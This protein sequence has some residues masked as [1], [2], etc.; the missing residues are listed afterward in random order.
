MGLH[1]FLG[2]VRQ[3]A[4]LFTA[5]RVAEARRIVANQSSAIEWRKVCT[6]FDCF[7]K[8]S[9]EDEAVTAPPLTTPLATTVDAVGSTAG[10]ALNSPY[11]RIGR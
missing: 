9:R 8:M 1:C 3:V 6:T 2:I 7:F 5:H 11:H 4:R 10:G